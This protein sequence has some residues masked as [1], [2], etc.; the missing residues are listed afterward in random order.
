[1]HEQVLQD[2][3]TANNAKHMWTIG[4]NVLEVSCYMVK[5]KLLLVRVFKDPGGWDMFGQ[6]DVTGQVDATLAAMDVYV[7]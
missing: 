1:M 3:L 6:L 2:W 4:G 7:A 5:T